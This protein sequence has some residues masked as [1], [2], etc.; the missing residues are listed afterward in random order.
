MSGVRRWVGRIEAKDAV[1]NGL[2]LFAKASDGE[3]EKTFER[4]GNRVQEMQNTNMHGEV[5]EKG[6]GQ[7]FG[8]NVVISTGQCF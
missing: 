2:K 4:E 3:M 7:C 1:K 5:H 6:S 8:S